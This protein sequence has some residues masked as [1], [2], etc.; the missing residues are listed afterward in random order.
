MET[1]PLLGLI[2]AIQPVPVLLLHMSKLMCNHVSVYL[3]IMN[4]AHAGMFKV[5]YACTYIT[6]PIMVSSTKQYQTVD[7]DHGN[8]R[9][10][11]HYNVSGNVD[12]TE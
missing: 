8:L 5:M 7:L 11:L 3:N 10:C 4:A 1:A 2:C 6:V 9:V 12:I